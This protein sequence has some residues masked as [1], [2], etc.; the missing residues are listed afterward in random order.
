MA[1]MDRPPS[2]T[3]T[4]SGPGRGKR[5]LDRRRRSGAMSAPPPTTSASATP[6]SSPALAID[7]TTTLDVFV[8]PPSPG[9]WT[10][11]PSPVA[12]PRTSVLLLPAAP[13]PVDQAVPYG[14]SA[15]AMAVDDAG[16]A[17]PAVA[18]GRK[19]AQQASRLQPAQV[20]TI[21]ARARALV[22]SPGNASARAAVALL[23]S[24]AGRLPPSVARK[25]AAEARRLK[26]T[27]LAD[28]LIATL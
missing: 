22:R 23:R 10:P 12:V 16:V 2:A 24:H 25:L 11:P 6:V 1:V 19:A 20:R 5:A 18:R 3:G 14:A 21:A 8:E 15:A 17:T 27:P 4:A 28:A 9:G 13:L 7:A 26:R